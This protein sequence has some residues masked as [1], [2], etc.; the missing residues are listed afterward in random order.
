MQLVG[1]LIRIKPQFEEQ[2][3]L[4]HQYTF[5]QVLKRIHDS[6]IRN[7]SIF[8]NKGLLFS[9]YE[10]HGQDLELDLAAMAEDIHTQNWWKL[11]D[12]MQEPLPDRAPDEWWS[13]LK[14]EI[15]NQSKPSSSEKRVALRSE[16]FDRK[17]ENIER[18]QNIMEAYQNKVSLHSLFTKSNMAFLYTELESDI[19]EKE[20]IDSL[21]KSGDNWFTSKEIFHT[22]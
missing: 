15:H 1:S 3:I 13:V 14:S 16:K 7:Y 5:P 8:L 12:P 19:E 18:L 22:N 4:L 11:T 20:L 17:K 9:Y 6:N 10:Y 21:N 2:Y